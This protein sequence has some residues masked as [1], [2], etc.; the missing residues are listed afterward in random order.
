MTKPITPHWKSL[1]DEFEL[2]WRL[3]GLAPKTV[4]GGWCVIPNPNGD[5]VLVGVS[6]NVWNAKLCFLERPRC[7]GVV[8]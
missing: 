8:P 2:D 7:C 6:V 4:K 3:A 5:G 1:L